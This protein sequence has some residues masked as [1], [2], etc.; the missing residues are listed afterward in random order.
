MT[1]PTCTNCGEPRKRRCDGGW[2]G[3]H[4][5]CLHCYKR[6]CKAGKPASGVPPVVSHAERVALSTATIRAAMAE[7]LEEYAT[8]RSW[9]ESVRGAA[10][11]VGLR[12]EKTV[13][14]Y[15]RAYQA[16]QQGESAA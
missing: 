3:A 6:W 7:R 11:W 16:Q 14:K 5:W 13:R 4:G 8:A 2:Q 12:D 10:Q 15:E 9:G 1:A